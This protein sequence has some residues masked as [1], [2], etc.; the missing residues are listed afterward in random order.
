MIKFDEFFKELNK[1]LLEFA[2]YSWRKYRESAV[3]D[4]K[5]FL[6]K[7]KTDLE[8]WV[9]LL[10]SGALTHD[11]FEWLIAGKK[12]LVEMYAL[13]QAGLTKVALDRFINGLIDTIVA[14]TFKMI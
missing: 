7:N 5:A 12:D 14:T 10:A 13:K 3:K 6:D 1:E 2:E 9:K 4:G 11:D 8:R